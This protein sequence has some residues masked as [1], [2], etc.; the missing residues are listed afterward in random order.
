MVKVSKEYFVELSQEEAILYVDK[1]EKLYKGQI[2]RASDQVAQIQA[3][4]VFVNEAIR[5]IL[6]LS[7]DKPAK[8]RQML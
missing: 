6:N 7:S 5:E 3:H 1:K 2:E 4:I 8:E